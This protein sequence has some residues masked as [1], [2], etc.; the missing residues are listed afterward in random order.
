MVGRDRKRDSG[1][2]EADRHERVREA[3]ALETAEDYAEAIAELIDEFGRCRV[4]DLSRHFGVSHVT[5]SRTIGRLERDGLVMTEPYQ[6]IELTPAGRRL[7]RRARH[8]HETVVRF[9]LAL[10]LDSQTAEFD[11]EGIEHHV[12]PKTLRAFGKFADDNE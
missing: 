11:A 9:L 2:R 10:G 8:R 5:V 7:A 1:V 6:P 4:V 3:H 12:S